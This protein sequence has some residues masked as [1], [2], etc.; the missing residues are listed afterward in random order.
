M[1][2]RQHGTVIEEPIGQRVEPAAQLRLLPGPPERTRRDLDEVRRPLD[3]AGGEGMGDGLR[4]LPLA[5]PPGAGA[6]MQA[7][8]VVGMLVEQPRAEEIG[9]QVVVAVPA[10]P[11][12]ERDEEQ[13]RPFERL[14]HRRPAGPAGHRV[15]QGS[16]EPVQDRGQEEE[17]AIGV[18]L[19]L[20]DLVGQIVDDEP[21]VARELR[22]ERR[23]VLASLHGD[24]GE[25]KRRDP[26]LGP[27][28]ERVHVGAQ[29]R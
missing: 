8:D 23:G 19:T 10:P 21:V 27:R 29:E 16:G 1:G 25:L 28:F 7:G 2:E 12:V 26:A 4:R 6:P 15:T 11:I 22:D 5:L 20:E 18:R 3:L 17:L 9:E 24:R 13:V 14:E